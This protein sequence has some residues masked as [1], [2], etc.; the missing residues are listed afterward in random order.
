MPHLEPLIYDLALI[1]VS[2]GI[3]TII[4]KFLKQP[5]VLGY[6]VVGFLAGP[7]FSLFPS[8]SDEHNIQVWAEIGIIFLL[9]SLGLEFSFKKLLRLGST[10]AVTSI[11]FIPGMMVLGFCAGHL[12]GWGNMNSIFLGGMIAMS[13]TTIII[14]AVT[15]LGMRKQKS[16]ELVFGILIVED[17][18]AIVLMVIFS[19]VGMQSHTENS[20]ALMVILKLVLFLVMWFLTG[21]YILPTFFK[22]TR[23]FLNSETLLVI[24]IGLCLGMVVLAVYSGFSS[25][26]GA[27][28]MGSILAETVQAERIEKISKPLKDLFGAV[29]FVSVGMM[30]NPEMIVKYAFPI[31]VLSII[32][33]IGKISFGTMGALTAGQPLKTSMQVGFSLAQIGEFSFIISTLGISLGLIDKFLYQVIVAVSVI[34]TF[35]TPYTMKL[36]EPAY[37]KLYPKL[38]DKWKIALYRYTSESERNTKKKNLWS[39]YLSRISR[40]IILYVLILSGILYL[41]FQHLIGFIADK[42]PDIWGSI[43]SALITL[44]LMASFLRALAV[45]ALDTKSF[46]ILWYEN[47]NNRIILVFIVTIRLMLPLVFVYIAIEHIFA[48]NHFITILYSILIYGIILFSG[49]INLQFM[50]I[51]KKFWDNLNSRSQFTGYKRNDLLHN[52]H[53]VYFTVSPNSIY[54][55]RKLIDAHIRQRFGVN[56]VSIM[57]GNEYINIPGAVEVIYPHDKIGVIGTDEQLEDFS[58][59]IESQEDIPGYN[60]SGKEVKLEHFTIKK[61]SGL[62]GKTIRESDVREKL[63]CLIIGIEREDGSF[64]TNNA[65]AVFQEDDVIWV[66]GEKENIQSVKKL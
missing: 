62:L 49:R 60:Q 40:Y 24:A 45:K 37:N 39:K 32:V 63:N 41:S 35:T 50:Q 44:L 55:G 53:L 5:V 57:R 14:K 34:T 7:Y 38:P 65:N 47:K 48:F 64:V 22:K 58:K 54:V 20:P 3:I 11:I 23:Q 52:L 56:I 15:D 31:A 21:I 43:L 25:A 66:V 6:I 4:F 16:T 2:A 12:L 17:L 19:S 27:F 1:L 9:F 51:E 46:K 42:V 28:V 8:V 30:V 13:S 36:A 61:H 59:Y 33:I 18:V 26:L 10:I 29:F